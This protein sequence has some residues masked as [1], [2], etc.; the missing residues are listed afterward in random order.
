MALQFYEAIG[1][2]AIPAGEEPEALANAIKTLLDKKDLELKMGTD[3][4]NKAIS[5]LRELE[6]L[7]TIIRLDSHPAIIREKPNES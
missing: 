6:K 1:D 5:N 3:C 7:S 2:E 4:V